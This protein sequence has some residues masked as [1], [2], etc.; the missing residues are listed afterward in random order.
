LRDGPVRATV[1]R[2]ALLVYQARLFLHRSQA[3]ANGDIRYRLG[4]SCVLCAK[5]C[6]APGIQVGALTWHLPLLRKIFLAWHRYV[7]GFVLLERSRADR[8]FIFRCTHFDATTRRCDSYSTR[9]GMCRDYPRPFLEQANPEF[10][11]GCGFKAVALSRD[12][13][14]RALDEVALT[15]DQRAKLSKELYLDDSGG[16]G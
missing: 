7:N 5:C 16:P 2:A 3:R 12:G 9:P 15:R 11:E 6:E 8:A 10:F 4:G 1:K 14:A 13:L